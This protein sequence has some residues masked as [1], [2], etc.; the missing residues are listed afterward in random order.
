VTT[1]ADGAVPELPPPPLADREEAD[2]GPR[3]FPDVP[4]PWVVVLGGLVGGVWQSALGIPWAPVGS[5]ALAAVIVFVDRQVGGKARPVTWALAGTALAVVQML[6]LGVRAPPSAIGWVFRAL[7]Y[8]VPYVLFGLAY[9]LFARWRQNP[10]IAFAGAGATAAA[11]H[12]AI[13]LVASAFAPVSG[14]RLMGLWQAQGFVLS[15]ASGALHGICFGTPI[16]AV[17]RRWR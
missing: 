16:A 13:W 8:I 11:L 14:P 3:Q 6:V 10:V 1:S 9:G 7:Q 12:S 2:A 15:L 17:E 4:L 5:L